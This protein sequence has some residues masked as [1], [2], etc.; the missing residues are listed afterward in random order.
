MAIEMQH[1]GS[2]GATAPDN[3]GAPEIRVTTWNILNPAIAPEKMFPCM[4]EDIWGQD[5]RRPIIQRRMQ[6]FGSDI[7]L[8]QEVQLSELNLLLESGQPALKLTYDCHFVEERPDLLPQPSKE[9]PA[10]NKK[11]DS[12]D[13]LPPESLAEDG[14]VRGVAVLWKKGVLTSVERLTEGAADTTNPAA[15]VR[16]QLA[17]GDEVLFAS[18]HLDALGCPPAVTRCKQ[19][20]VQVGEDA[21]EV[22]GR[23]PGIVAIFGG[24]CNLTTAPAVSAMASV[25]YRAASGE[26]GP[27]T[28]FSAVSSA[29]FDHIFVRG[30]WATQ[31]VEIPDCPEPH[32]CPK[33]PCMHQ[34]QMGND[35]LG[36][37][38]PKVPGIGLRLLGC[39]LCP[40]WFM[41]ALLCFLVPMPLHVRRCRWA[42]QEWGSDHVPV[43][44]VLRRTGDGAD[45]V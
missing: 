14:D 26:A 10:A 2:G 31:S 1:A 7:L 34:L 22:L 11:G 44:V 35:L 21:L 6:E 39:L 8:L 19:Q 25:G 37:S 27:A 28:C 33:T 15:F 4:G 16:G 42:L 5:N 13:P 40:L 20:I 9:A 38:K 30:A 18:R 29:T 24:D 36:I 23:K 12:A 17:C 45:S 43:T 3:G 32:C 41:G